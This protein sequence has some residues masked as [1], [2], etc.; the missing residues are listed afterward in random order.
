[1]L[2]RLTTPYVCKKVELL[3]PSYIAFESIR[4]Y[5]HFRKLFGIFLIKFQIQL[6]YDSAIPLLGSCPREVKTYAQPKVLYKHGYGSF[7]HNSLKVETTPMI[8]FIRNTRTGKMNLSN[9]NQ[10]SDCLVGGY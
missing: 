2:K 1:M 6:S 5:N 3:K 4:W 8:S 10:N 9:K 7:I